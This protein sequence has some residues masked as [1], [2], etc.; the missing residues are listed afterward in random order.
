M[1]DR[2]LEM[3]KAAE[4]ASDNATFMA[5]LEARNKQ[6]RAVSESKKS[7]GNYAP[8]EFAE[9]AESK[10]IGRVR[11]EQAM[12]RLF[13]VGA[14]ERGFLWVYKGEGKSCFGLRPV[15]GFKGPIAS[16]SFEDGGSMLSETQQN[17]TDSMGQTSYRRINGETQQNQTDSMADSM[18]VT[19][20]SLPLHTPPQT[21]PARTR[22]PTR[23]GEALGSARARDVW[24]DDPPIDSRDDDYTP[25]EWGD[26]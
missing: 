7:G 24:D 14:I 13:R 11:L 22:A 9:M 15:S 26:E 25:I 3:R 6:R 18:P 1:P 17:Q 20:D 4:A 2:S 19:S 16:D 23:E 5:C 12:D 21:P 10:G 8:K